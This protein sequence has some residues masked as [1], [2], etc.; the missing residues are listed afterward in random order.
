[1]T[2]RTGWLRRE[3]TVGFCMLLRR[4][5]SLAFGSLPWGKRPRSSAS[6]RSPPTSPV[7]RSCGGT[8]GGWGHFPHAPS[9][10]SQA[11]RPM[12][13]LLAS[14]I[15][16]V[17]NGGGYVAGLLAALEAQTIAP[18][19][20]EVLI[21][22]DGSRDGALAGIEAGRP[23][24]RV[25]AGPPRNSYAARNMAVR[26]SRAPVLAFCDVDCRPGARLAR[27][28]PCRAGRRRPCSR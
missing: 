24:L 25:V 6:H 8:K 15:V 3:D 1:M 5:A 22:D 14:V 20:F 23:W 10:R 11:L 2:R 27:G 16:P 9:T 28:R 18:G 21:G 19:R 7:L 26:A 13:E 4:W 12:S 17:R